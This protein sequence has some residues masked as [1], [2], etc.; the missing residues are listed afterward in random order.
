MGQVSDLPHFCNSISITENHLRRYPIDSFEMAMEMTLIG[1]T[2]L[3][4][5]IADRVLLMLQQ[6]MRTLNAQI[7]QVLMGWHAGCFFEKPL[8]GREGVKEFLAHELAEVLR[9]KYDP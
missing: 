4:C 3:Q 8:T 6:L 5:H 7:D 9:L 1:K 2:Y